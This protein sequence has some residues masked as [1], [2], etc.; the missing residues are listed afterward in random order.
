MTNRLNVQFAVIM[1]LLIAISIGVS[2]FINYSI[3]RGNVIEKARET[4]VLTAINLSDQVTS[5]VNNA[6]NSVK[7]TVNAL[8]LTNMS[9]NDR[10]VSFVKILNYNLNIKK[11]VYGRHARRDH[12]VN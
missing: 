3:E 5:Y 11:Y 4:N 7:T 8:D 12:G 9:T 1:T 6:I 2:G 10:Q